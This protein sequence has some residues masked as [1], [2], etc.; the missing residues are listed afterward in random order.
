MLRNLCRE[1][2]LS[3]ILQ[4]FESPL[5]FLPE[6]GQWMER[7][8]A[9]SWTFNCRFD[10]FEI[11]ADQLHS[12]MVGCSI[13]CQ[14]K[15]ALSMG[16]R[17]KPASCTAPSSPRNSLA[18]SVSG[19]FWWSWSTALQLVFNRSQAVD[20]DR[21]FPIS[22]NTNTQGNACAPPGPWRSRS[23]FAHR[24]SQGLQYWKC[25]EGT[26]SPRGRPE[27]LWPSILGPGH[28]LAGFQL[29]H[30]ILFLGIGRESHWK[31]PVMRKRNGCCRTD[32]GWLSVSKTGWL[33]Q[34]FC[35]GWSPELRLSAGKGSC[36]AIICCFG[37]LWVFEVASR[38]F[39]PFHLS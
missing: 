26:C 30:F 13:Q 31:V 15:E 20:F 17:G 2:T 11:K 10:T 12:N 23:E 35:G 22:L 34:E 37:H 6:F 14:R 19:F 5:G 9:Y 33:F 36:P 25:C 28:A 18:F 29:S 39:L 21:S 32:F 1:I 27:I 8:Q 3:D 38:I 7:I 24:S 4:L 16:K